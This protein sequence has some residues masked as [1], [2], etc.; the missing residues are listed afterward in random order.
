MYKR[1]FEHFDE[2][3]PY[4]EDDDD[5]GIDDVGGDE[6]DEP[7][8]SV[9]LSPTHVE[10]LLDLL[11][12]V[13]DQV[14]DEEGG[15]DIEDLDAMDDDEDSL[16]AEALLV[17]SIKAKLKA[18][19]KKALVAAGL[20]TGGLVL[21]SGKGKVVYDEVVKQATR[22]GAGATEAGK[23]ATDAVRGAFAAVKEIKGH[24]DAKN[25]EARKLAKQNKQNNEATEMEEVKPKDADNPKGNNKVGNLKASGGKASSTSA[26]GGDG[27]ASEMTPKG[28]DNPKGSNKVADLQWG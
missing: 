16:V 15:D 26:K 25:K 19:A 6:G 28:A 1:Q 22:L 24:N 3:S 7:S 14:G 9:Q 2:E 13:E 10:A 17:E 11:S 27:S 4:M 23:L 12:Q 18:A 5:L 20:V 21:S 8:V